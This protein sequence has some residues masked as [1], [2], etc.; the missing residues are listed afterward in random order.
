MKVRTKDRN[1]KNFYISGSTVYNATP[2]SDTMFTI[3][4]DYEHTP[5]HCIWRNCSH[6]DGGDWELV[7]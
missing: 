7:E 2:I 4:S 5:A 6:L 1:F 3:I